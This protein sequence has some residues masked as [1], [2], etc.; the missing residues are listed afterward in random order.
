ME[1]VI[2][3]PQRSA[4]SNKKVKDLPSIFLYFRIFLK[5]IHIWTIDLLNDL[6]LFLDHFLGVTTYDVEVTR[7]SVI[8]LGAEVR[9]SLAMRR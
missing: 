2:T 4:S 6:V 7:F 3:P 8:D 5:N 9:A 1:S